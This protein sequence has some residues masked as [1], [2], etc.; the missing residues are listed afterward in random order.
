MNYFCIHK[1]CYFLVKF[2]VSLIIFV[3]DCR[4]KC[5]FSRSQILKVW[6]YFSKMHILMSHFVGGWPYID[7]CAVYT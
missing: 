5:H 4:Y 6:W 2:V 7:I 1:K 3:R